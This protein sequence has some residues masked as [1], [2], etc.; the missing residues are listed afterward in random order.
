MEHPQEVGHFRKWLNLE[1]SPA[2][3]AVQAHDIMRGIMLTERGP[4]KFLKKCER[5]SLQQIWMACHPMSQLPQAADQH[6]LRWDIM[7]RWF[8]VS[9]CV[10]I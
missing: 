10:H 3:L 2:S 5:I 1:P 4:Y 6:T 8:E 7:L 9:A